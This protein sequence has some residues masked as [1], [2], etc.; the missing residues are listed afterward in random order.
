M[1]SKEKIHEQICHCIL[2]RVQRRILDSRYAGHLFLT[3][4]NIDLSVINLNEC[5]VRIQ[6]LNISN[7]AEELGEAFIDIFADTID[8]GLVF[9]MDSFVCTNVN[10][11]SANRF[12]EVRIAI[13]SCS[14]TVTLKIFVVWCA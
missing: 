11:D 13:V 3:D 2:K 14:P 6:A 8:D 9:D 5:S 1:E 12:V 4:S 7:N 10:I